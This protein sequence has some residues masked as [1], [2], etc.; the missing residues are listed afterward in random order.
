MFFEHRNYLPSLFLFLPAGVL[1]AHIL[2]GK[3]QQT[4]FRR[5][6]VAS[7][8]TLFLIISAHATYTRNKAWATE[9]SLWSDALRK[10]PDSARASY[11]VA[12]IRREKKQYSQAYYM[13]QLTLRKADKSLNHEPTDMKAACFNELGIINHHTGFYEPALEYYNKC[14]KLKNDH[15]MCLRNR[16]MAYLELG[17]FEKSFNDANKL[18]KLH[19]KKTE[20]QYLSLLRAI[21]SRI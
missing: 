11:M 5:I 16:S 7:C 14:L 18:T 9:D 12:F 10:S 8:T 4:V 21:M 1:I 13:Y 15:E 19:P 6:A 2:Y 17:Q 20:Y 3:I